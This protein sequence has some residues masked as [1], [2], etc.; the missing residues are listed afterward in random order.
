MKLEDLISRERTEARSWFNDTTDATYIS[1]LDCPT[2]EE[3]LAAYEAMVGE[4]WEADYLD[5]VVV[6]ILPCCDHDIEDCVPNPE[7]RICGKS[8]DQKVW[9]FEP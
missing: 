3:A 9:A 5:E 7:T 1:A 6:K 4:P 8:V 2:R